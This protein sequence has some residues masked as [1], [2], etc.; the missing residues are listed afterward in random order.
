MT[1]STP[2]ATTS[3]DDLSASDDEGEGDDAGPLPRTPASPGG[4][5]GEV[6]RELARMRSSRY[7]HRTSVDEASG[8]FDYDCSGFVSYALAR[9][10]PSSYEAVRAF[11]GRRPLAKNYVAWIV[12]LGATTRSSW[13][14]VRDVAQLASGDLVAWLR[15]PDAASRSTGHVMVVAGPP[16]ALS[17]SE[18]VVTVVDSSASAHGR[19][20]TRATARANGLG[21]GS[22]VL[23]TDASGAPSAYRWSEAER[24][25]THATH[26]VLARILGE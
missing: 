12:S 8:R 11:A 22:I 24:S 26:I 17:P 14:A 21:R 1:A 3:D 20:D 25:R 19:N 23:V 5:F 2:A 15:P 9:A 6:E 16:R 13:V 4:L 10:A 7:V 18:W